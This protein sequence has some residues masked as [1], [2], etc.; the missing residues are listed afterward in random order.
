MA[1]DEQPSAEELQR[2]RRRRA[3]VPPKLITDGP[4]ID[5]DDAGSDKSITTSTP[6]DDIRD[7][8]DDDIGQQSPPINHNQSS[9]CEISI[10][11]ASVSNKSKIS[12]RNSLPSFNVE[13]TGCSGQSSSSIGVEP[14]IS[15]GS[16]SDNPDSMDGKRK[17]TPSSLIGDHGDDRKSPRSDDHSSTPSSSSSNLLGVNLHS[18]SNKNNRRRSSVVVIPPMQICPGDLL[19]YSKVL[20]QRANLIAEGGGFASSLLTEHDNR[21]SHKNTWSLLRLVSSFP[22]KNHSHTHRMLK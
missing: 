17:P 22:S 6:N 3:L 2:R 5:D 10:I 4:S 13:I 19:V 15:D 16:I 21:K 12:G 7:D 18:P 14:G 8:V 1:P 9:K 11:D 20:T